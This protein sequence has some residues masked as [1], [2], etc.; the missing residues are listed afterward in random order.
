MTAFIT[1]PETFSVCSP[2]RRTESK[3]M[4]KIYSHAELF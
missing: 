4:R 2:L 3:Q 1:E